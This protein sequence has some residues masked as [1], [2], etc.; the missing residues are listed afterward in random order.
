LNH[1]LY[2]SLV[3]LTVAGDSLLDR[4]WR[5]LGNMKTCLRAGE[6]QDSAGLTH[7]NGRLGIGAEEQLLDSSLV[8]LKM[9]DYLLACTVNCD[10][11]VGC[12]L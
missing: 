6:H 5:V 1:I 4:C 9:A 8:R 10:E 2:L 7:R 3:C 12:R 11:P